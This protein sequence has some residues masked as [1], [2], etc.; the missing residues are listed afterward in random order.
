[1]ATEAQVPGPGCR[2][3]TPRKVATTLAQM[4]SAAAGTALRQAQGRLPLQPAG[5]RRYGSAYPASR[6]VLGVFGVA[7]ANGFLG[8]GYGGGDYVFA[9]GPFTEI[10]EAAAVTA[11]REVGVGALD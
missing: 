1:M 6:F 2:W 11:E 5:R 8:V 9:A 10:D 4:G 7:V 3:P